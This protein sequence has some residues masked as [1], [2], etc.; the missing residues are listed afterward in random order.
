MIIL[1]DA[2]QYQSGGGDGWQIISFDRR[3]ASLGEK[4]NACMAL[5]SR[6][7]WALVNWDDDDRY[8]EHSLS[9]I[10]LSLEGGDFA[11]PSKVISRNADNKDAVI[12][13]QYGVF[14]P[15]WGFTKEC[16]TK[17][18]RYPNSSVGE[19]ENLLNRAKEF[20][21]IADPI[22]LGAK[23]YFV[24]CHEPGTYHLAQTQNYDDLSAEK[25][26]LERTRNL[27]LMVLA[28]EY[29]RSRR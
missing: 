9:S 2:G 18:G 27:N 28:N 10:A 17:L 11:I 12:S 13:A 4:R 1:D 23:P 8:L 14:H 7:T 6:D 26:Y 22:Q 19:D 15:S 5:A 20:C 21:K 25:I 16:F 3:F 24:W 29:E